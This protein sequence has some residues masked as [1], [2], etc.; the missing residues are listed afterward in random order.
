MVREMNNDYVDP[1]TD[2]LPPHRLGKLGDAQKVNC[3][4][5][6]QGAYKPL[7]G[8]NVIKDYPNLARLTAQET[9]MPVE[10]DTTDMPEPAASMSDMTTGGGD[11]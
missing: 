9:E 7:L 2:W 5:C 3:E 4:T 11:Q 8:A 10:E 1:T 6:H